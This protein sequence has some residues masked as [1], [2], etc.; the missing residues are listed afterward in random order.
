MTA[1][2]GLSPSQPCPYHFSMTLEQTLWTTSRNPATTIGFDI[3]DT[4]FLDHGRV[5]AC[6]EGNKTSRIDKMMR[7]RQCQ[8]SHVS[9]D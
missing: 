1:Y 3:F 4:T 6:F 7:G 5:V 9:K 2:S 8:S